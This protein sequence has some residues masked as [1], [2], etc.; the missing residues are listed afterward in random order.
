MSVEHLPPSFSW[1]KSL[2][3]QVEKKDQS[4]PIGLNSVETQIAHLLPLQDGVRR[5]GPR[6]EANRKELNFILILCGGGQV[7][8][9]TFL[10]TIHVAESSFYHFV[11]LEEN[12][13]GGK[14]SQ[15]G[16]SG[17]GGKVASDV[18]RQI[19]QVFFIIF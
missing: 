9:F 2:P 18:G 8:I 13:I 17:Q 14:Y 19:R 16:G 5:Q 6:V 11:N 4:N 3:D 7:V 15:G 12:N 10:V 1:A